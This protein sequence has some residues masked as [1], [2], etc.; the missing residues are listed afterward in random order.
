M[1]LETESKFVT[2]YETVDL[3][4]EAFKKEF[5]NDDSILNVC[6]GRLLQDPIK[7]CIIAQ[8][9]RHNPSPSGGYY[10]YGGYHLFFKH[11]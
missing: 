5:Q 7:D 6:S 11:V 2:S 3:A 8:T 9:T 1:N 4:V 10:W